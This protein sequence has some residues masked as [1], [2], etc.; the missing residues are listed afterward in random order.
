MSRPFKRQATVWRITDFHNKFEMVSLTLLVAYSVI[1]MLDQNIPLFRRKLPD[2]VVILL[3]ALPSLA[4]FFVLK[5][6]LTL[7]WCKELSRVPRKSLRSKW[8]EGDDDYSGGS[9]QSQADTSVTSDLVVVRRVEDD[10]SSEAESDLS[11]EEVLQRPKR[12]PLVSN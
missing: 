12:K 4:T 9:S 3:L 10:E 1:A 6:E 7:S 5:I 2:P 11:R 8:L